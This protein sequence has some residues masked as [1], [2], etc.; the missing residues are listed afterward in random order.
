MG[1]WQKGRDLLWY[2]KEG[3]EE[4]IRGKSQLQHELDEVRQRDEDMLNEALGIKVKKRKFEQPTLE[5]DEMKQLFT[6]GGREIDTG[7]V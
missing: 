6:K 3:N 2:A 5:Q 1:R 7:I 4:V